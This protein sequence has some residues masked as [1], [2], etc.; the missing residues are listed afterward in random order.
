LVKQKRTRKIKALQ[1]RTASWDEQD[2]EKEV[3]NP[4]NE[5][6]LTRTIKYVGGGKVKCQ[7]T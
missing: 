6:N 5:Q 7:A 3:D 4:E 2:R 1:R